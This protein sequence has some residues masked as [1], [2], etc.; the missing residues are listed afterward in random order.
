MEV[1]E[2][3]TKDPTACLA[4]DSCAAA[5]AIMRSRNCG[6]VPVVDSEAAKRVIG[7]VTDRDILLH[8]ARTDQRAS[9]GCVDAC[10][11]PSPQTIGPHADL[12]DAAT[13]ME[14][15]AVHRLPVVEE[16][17]LVGVLSL[18]DIA[19]AA[20]Q[21]WASGGP[22]IAERQLTDILEAIAEA[23]IHRTIS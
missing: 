20:K 7:V 12:L 6:F 15:A 2:L 9:E 5:V 13:V 4:S 3:M 21:R 1:C 16:G 14:R 11:T 22:N 17:T 18:K 23:Q 19:R 10:M 8:L